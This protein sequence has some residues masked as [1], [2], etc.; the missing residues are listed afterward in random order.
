MSGRPDLPDALGARS[1]G[2][3]FVVDGC[4]APRA[5]GRLRPQGRGGESSTKVSGSI[6][7]TRTLLVRNQWRRVNGSSTEKHA[8]ITERISPKI[9]EGQLSRSFML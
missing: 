4:R 5:G 1:E 6:Q 3:G 2:P 9:G 7:T 8:P